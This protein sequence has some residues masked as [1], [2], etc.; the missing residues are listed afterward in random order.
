MGN[1]SANICLIASLLQKKFPSHKWHFACNALR[2]HPEY[3]GEAS[4]SQRSFP[5]TNPMP[6]LYVRCCR[7][8]DSIHHCLYDYAPPMYLTNPSQQLEIVHAP[9]ASGKL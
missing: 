4:A 9:E 7:S 5:H 6:I 3:L 2:S 1:T 8:L